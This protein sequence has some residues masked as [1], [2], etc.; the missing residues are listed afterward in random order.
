VSSFFP[1]TISSTKKEPSKHWYVITLADKLKKNTSY[2]LDLSFRGF[3][4][5][6]TT[7]GFFRASYQLH[8]T[9]EERLAQE[10]CRLFIILFQGRG[11]RECTNL[12][13]VNPLLM[14]WELKSLCCM[15]DKSGRKKVIL[16]LANCIE[17]CPKYHISMYE[18]CT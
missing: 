8:R 14:T 15:V 16:L 1:V 5:N 17:V 12:N 7:Q 13:S 6:D 3:L 11:E 10:N 18:L 2:Q 9:K 4:S